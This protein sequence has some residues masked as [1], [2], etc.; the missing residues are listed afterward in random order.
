MAL[1][2]WAPWWVGLLGGIIAI[3]L[4][5]HV[6]GG[7]GQNL[8]NPAMIARIALVVSFPVELTRYVAPRPIFTDSAPNAL[9]SLKIFLG[10]SALDMDAMSSASV[11]S[12][13][14]SEMS[15][16][17]PL[18]DI[19]GPDFPLMDLLIG[20]T[21]GCLGET[22]GA[23]LLLGGLILLATRVITWH[24]PVAVIA[25]ILLPASIAHMI[26]PERFMSPA[27]HALAASTLFGAF[28]IATDLVTS[29]TTTRGQLVYGAGIGLLIFIIRTW[30][31]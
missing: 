20:N 14:K 5:K 10:T 2:P 1:P 3:G 6:F 23:L 26:D 16:G 7:L 19:F 29:P 28:F 8:F 4:A 31:A 13:A 30:G 21:T 25:A 27:V 15:K 11:L 12:H 22:S 9:E 24:I 17:T 18:T